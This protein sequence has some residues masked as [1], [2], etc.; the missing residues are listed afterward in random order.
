[1]NAMLDRRDFIRALAA[2]AV[3]AGVPL[4]VGF[5][6]HLQVIGT[7]IPKT[8]ELLHWPDQISSERQ[9]EAAA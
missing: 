9:L 2:G 1:M 8:L 5:P 3:A 4:P 7:P 6:R